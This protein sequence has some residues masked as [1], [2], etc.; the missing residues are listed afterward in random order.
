MSK[1]VIGLDIECYDPLLKT[2]GYSWKYNQGYILNTALYDEDKDKVAV[3]AGIHNDN[4]PYDAQTREEDNR[5]CIEMLLRNP[6][7]C[8][9][10][11]NLQYDIGWLLYEFN[12]STYDVKCSFVDVL[13]AEAILDEFGVHSLESVSQ[14]YLKY[15]KSKDQIEYWVREHVSKKGDFREH[16]KDA[17]WDM[18]VEGEARNV[19]VML[20]TTRRTVGNIYNDIDEELRILYVGVTRTKQN[21]F[22]VDSKNGSGYDRLLQVIKE[23]NR[24]EW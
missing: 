20:D 1:R 9:V 18:L 10:G 16:L 3:I 7:I 19:A 5:M 2:A 4:C 14:K 8:S 13:Q 23:E 17:P 24:L 11:A 12:M 15:G 6:D 22:L 21:L